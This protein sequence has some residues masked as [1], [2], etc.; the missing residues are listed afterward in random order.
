[1][2]Q[3]VDV[4]N[5]NADASCLPC[6]NW[7]E[8]LQGGSRS[9][10]S[11]WLKLYVD[12]GKKMV[13]GLTGATIADIAQDNPEAI[14]LI[15][16]NPYIFE[17]LLRPFA[18]D[19][20]LLR[21]GKGFLVNFEYGRRAISREFKNICS[22]FLPPEFM[23]TNEQIVQ[24][25]EQKVAGAFI[26]PAR[27]SAEIK[28]RLPTTPYS[29]RG[30][31]NAR[32]HCIPFE[33]KLTEGYLHALH[34]FD[35]SRWNAGVQ[36]AAQDVVFSWRDGESSFLLPDGLARES[37][38]LNNEEP[39]FARKHIGELDLEFVPSERLEE[40]YYHSYPVHSFSAWMKEFRMLGFINRVQRI[41]EGLER[42]TSE[43]VYYW[44]MIINSDIMSAIEKR[45]PVVTLKSAPGSAATFDFTIRRSE[46]GFEGEEYLAI[47][48]AALASNSMPHYVTSSALPH[49]MKWRNRIKYL[50]AL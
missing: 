48:E 47:L 7:L 45:S 49:V 25:R 26:N 12:S 36:A 46:R 22:Y 37:F 28:K 15:N 41:E 13:L 32:L 42:L 50:N 29:L 8:A 27:F 16:R 20:A 6:R 2:K 34:M 4:V 33:G 38:W 39:T 40:H 3:I 21:Q 18:H 19:I 17:I 30:L 23:L 10:L 14:E 9:P 43:Q 31:F 5:F 1:M 35:C 24:L 44:L 11:Q